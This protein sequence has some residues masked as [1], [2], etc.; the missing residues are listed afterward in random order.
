MCERQRPV[1]GRSAWL[2]A[3]AC[4]PTLVQPGRAGPRGR[5]VPSAAGFPW[6]LGAAL[7]SAPAASRGAALAH[8][9]GRG[10]DSA[11][12]LAACVVPINRP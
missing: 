4:V 5:L 12:W 6:A 2:S 3:C 8:A 1:V 11:L 10:G 7:P 9:E